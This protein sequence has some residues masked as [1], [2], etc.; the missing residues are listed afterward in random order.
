MA[1]RCARLVFRLRRGLVAFVRVRGLVKMPFML[2]FGRSFL[3]VRVTAAKLAGFTLVVA[4]VV[5]IVL[6]R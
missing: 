4:S 6:C 3:R 2:G 5:L 1:T